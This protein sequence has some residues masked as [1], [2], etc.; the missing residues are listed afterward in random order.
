MSEK[1]ICSFFDSAN[2][3]CEESVWGEKINDNNHYKVLNIP[4][5]APNLALYDVVSITKEDDHL[6]F[7]DLITASGHST[8]QIVFLKGEAKNKVIER[9][10]TLGCSWEGMH[11]QDYLAIDIPKKNIYSE[12][13]L[14]LSSEMN[15][16]TLDYKE[17]CIA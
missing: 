6:Y 1:I 14:F 11:N 5:F 12:V 17:A 10:E 8:V 13:I 7:D 3:I 4:F 2:E 16:N 15:E 9:L